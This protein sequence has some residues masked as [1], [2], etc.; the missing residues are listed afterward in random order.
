[1]KSK[2]KLQEDA[3]RTAQFYL[4]ATP[5]SNYEEDLEHLTGAVQEYVEQSNWLCDTSNTSSLLEIRKHQSLFE[6]A[7]AKIEELTS[8]AAHAVCHCLL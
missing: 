6:R 5:D 4:E 8:C 3:Y 7:A 1:M 2:K